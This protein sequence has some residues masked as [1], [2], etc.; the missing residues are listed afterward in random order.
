[1]Q[2]RL[3]IQQIDDYIK[4]FESQNNYFIMQFNVILSKQK[5]L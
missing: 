4:D 2:K 3:R 1:M 5:Q